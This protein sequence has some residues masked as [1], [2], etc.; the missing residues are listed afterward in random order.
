MTTVVALQVL[1]FF[2]GASWG[3]FLNVVIYRL[4]LGLSLVRPGSRCPSCETPIKPYDNIPVLS[5]LILRG[6]C[7]ACKVSINPRYMLVEIACGVICLA[8]FRQAVLPLSPPTMLVDMAFWQWGF[9]LALGLVA[10]AF[11]DL[12]HIIIPHEITFPLM[13][14]GVGGAFALPHVDGMTS[15]WG[16]LAGGGSIGVIYVVA[17]LIYRREAMGLGDVTLT[18]MIGAFLGPRPL[19]L[20]VLAACIQALLAV[21]IVTLYQ[22]ITGKEGE[23][24]RTM[25]EIDAHFGEEHPEDHISEKAA[26]PFGP[27]L[28]LGA[29]EALLFGDQWFWDLSDRFSLALA[30]LFGA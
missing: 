4:P 21:A 24:V 22:K 2:W 16:L 20:V 26:L 10:V 6:R 29:L 7:R 11:I 18:A 12:E 13:V 15:L 30:Q 25:G 14:I 8:M 9:A 17:L 23:L 1:A 5:W 27:F 19:L 28:A 3:S